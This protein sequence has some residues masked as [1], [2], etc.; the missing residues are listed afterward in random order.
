MFGAVSHTPLRWKLAGRNVFKTIALM[1]RDNLAI[2]HP[3]VDMGWSTEARPVLNA[4]VPVPDPRRHIGST[5]A[6][7]VDRAQE[8][9]EVRIECRGLFEIDGVA[10]VGRYPEAG[11]GKRRLQH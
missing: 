1:Q 2:V 3:L 8:G 11:I 10:S 5:P 9:F 4:Q 7:A 6:P